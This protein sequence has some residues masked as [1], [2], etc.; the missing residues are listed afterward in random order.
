MLIGLIFKNKHNLIRCLLSQLNDLNSSAE[1]FHLRQPGYLLED[2]SMALRPHLT[3]G[4]PF[5]DS[6]RLKW[7]VVNPYPA[8][9]T[10]IS[11]QVAIVI[12]SC[13]HNLNWFFWNIHLQFSDTGDNLKFKNKPARVAGFATGSTHASL[14]RG[15]ATNLKRAD[16][17]LHYS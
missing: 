14:P 7:T 8:S 4:L 5:R 12:N 17:R 16:Q 11:I 1:D 3:M 10:K 2:R 9:Q 15:W 6:Y 13:N